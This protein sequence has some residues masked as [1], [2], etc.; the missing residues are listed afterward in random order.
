[1]GVS[2][3]PSREE[4]FSSLDAVET[5][6]GRGR[7]AQRGRSLVIP[8]ALVRMRMGKAPLIGPHTG[9]RCWPLLVGVWRA[10]APLMQQW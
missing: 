2:R 4:S 5:G 3:C 9:E 8:H 7:A 1:M 6:K 10:I